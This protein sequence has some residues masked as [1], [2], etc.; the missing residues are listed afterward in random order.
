MSNLINIEI[1]L[2][3]FLGCIAIVVFGS[4]LLSAFY[5][6]FSHIS[7]LLDRVCDTTHKLRR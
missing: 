4:A 2:T 5:W 3:V 1:A 6:I 7:S